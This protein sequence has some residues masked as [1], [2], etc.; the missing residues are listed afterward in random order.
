MTDFIRNKKQLIEREKVESEARRLALEA[1]EAALASVNPQHLLR[2]RL[3]L[4][5]D[6]LRIDHLSVDLKEVEGI[7]VFG[8]GKASAAMA[9]A[10][11]EVLGDR[12][13]E[14]IIVAPKYQE[15]AFRTGPIWLVKAGHPIPTVEAPNAVSKMLELA[16]RLGERDLAFC[17]ISGG[18]SALMA[19]P[20]GG[21][22]LEE[23]QD[24]TRALLKSGATIHEI[25]TVRKHL[26]QVKGG[27][28][29]G[30]IY[31]AETVGLIISDV[32]GDSLETI[33]SGPTAP[34][35]TTFRDAVAVLKKYRLWDNAPEA[36]RKTLEEGVGGLIPESP[37]P[38]EEVFRK[39]HNFILG[40]NEL[41]CRSAS[42]YLN[43]RGVEASVLTVFL[44]GE[45][46]EAGRVIAAMAKYLK[47]KPEAKDRSIILGGETTV[48]VKG[49]GKGGRNQ[50]LVLSACR[51]IEGVKGLAIAAVDTDGV[52]GYTE[53]AGGIVDGYTLSQAREAGL[54]ADFYLQN[55]D[56]HSFLDKLG[57]TIMTGPTGTN[58][59]DLI[60]A[61]RVSSEGG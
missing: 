29:A 23:K 42:E 35:P 51:L 37:K 17:L 4:E 46:R 30:R 50:E 15:R 12:L 1:M 24:I 58:V 52:D 7:Y 49:E 19:S 40:N 44:E 20:T 5:G 48:K 31:P 9:E 56:S 59:N 10:L 33:A 6:F 39:V 32:V 38:S 11:Y 53:A 28:L 2:G 36:V 25:N 3:K 61:V 41:A 26:S 43:S 13:T 21:V 60:V 54:D 27:R 47:P 14:G 22:S 16:D 34:D 45:A 18:G 57:D 8:G 55:N